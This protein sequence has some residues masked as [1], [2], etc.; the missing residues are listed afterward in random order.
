VSRSLRRTLA[1]R[2][3]ATMGVGLLAAAA[4]AYFGS[5]LVLQHGFDPSFVHRAT[6]IALVGVVLLG[7][8]ATF[9]GAWWL[10]GSAVR[11][12]HEITE[13]ATRVEAGTLD[14]RI[15]AH[16]DTDEYRGLVAVLNRMLERLGVAF[17][18]QRRLTADVSHELRSPLTALRGEIEVALRAERSPRDYQRVLHSALEEIDRLSEMSEDLL[19]ITRAEAK[20]LRPQRRPTDVNELVEDSLDALRARVEERELTVDRRLAPDGAGASIDPAL[21]G[22]VV[23]QLLDNAVKFTPPGGTIRVATACRGDGAGVRLSVEDSGPGIPPDQLSHIFEPFYRADQAR[24]RGT[25]TGLGLAMAA[26]IARLHGGA[27]HA[28]NLSGAGGG[29][30]GGGARFEVELPSASTPE[31]ASVT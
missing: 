30:G 7:T 9:V 5:H 20:L 31:P 6:I 25:G 24:S 18:N 2:F 4:A 12:V 14:Q 11:P 10:A 3:A 15:V 21:V 29:G 23:H 28:S 1:V 27:I 13:Q 26:A 8:G 17:E 22:R 19:L 16:A